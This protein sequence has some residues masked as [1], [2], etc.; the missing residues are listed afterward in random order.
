MQVTQQQ[1]KQASNAEA[2]RQ[3]ASAGRAVE[4]GA[5]TVAVSAE[6]LTGG[7]AP[8]IPSHCSHSSGRFNSIDHEHIIMLL[9]VVNLECFGMRNLMTAV[10]EK[11]WLDALI[12]PCCTIP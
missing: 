6:L 8:P 2:R 9:W 3:P 12:R 11:F 7:P 1:E 10:C 5:S 4:G